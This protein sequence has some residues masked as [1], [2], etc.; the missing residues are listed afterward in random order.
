MKILYE[1]F[2]NASKTSFL[3]TF[4]TKKKKKKNLFVLSFAGYLKETTAKRD[5]MYVCYVILF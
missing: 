1:W 4:P 3:S 5:Y 2:I